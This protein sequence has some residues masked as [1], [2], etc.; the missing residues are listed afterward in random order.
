[1]PVIA[2]GSEFQEV[3][4]KVEKLS[5]PVFEKADSGIVL[6]EA[7]NKNLR[8]SI[9]LFKGLVAFN[10]DIPTLFL[11]L[12][13][14]HQLLGENKSALENFA[15]AARGLGNISDLATKQTLAEVQYLSAI[16][17]ERQKQYPEAKMVAEKATELV[18]ESSNYWTVL[19]STEMQLKEIAACKKHLEKALKLD[20]ANKR[21]RY[22]LRM[23]EIAKEG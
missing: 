1:M 3:L 21:A 16:S 12:G 9:R 23:I 4:V 11:G 17:F 2:T 13:K 19:A 22:L 10:P 18:P 5:R 15:M 6:E 7:D 8:E 14:A 20:P